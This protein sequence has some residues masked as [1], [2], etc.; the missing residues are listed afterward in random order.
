[1]ASGFCQAYVIPAI[2]TFN[3]AV[4]TANRGR[5]IGLAAAGLSLCQGVSLAAGGGV[6]A[7]AGPAAAVACFAAGGLIGL[8]AL[9]AWWPARELSALGDDSFGVVGQARVELAAGGLDADSLDATGITEEGA[10]VG[11]AGRVAD[12]VSA[13]PALGGDG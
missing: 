4:D 11:T 10:G 2:A 7:A 8:A 9:R 5:A 3:L 6:A 1:M 13:V 12:A